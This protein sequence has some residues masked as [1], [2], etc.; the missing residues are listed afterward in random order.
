MEHLTLLNNK[1]IALV[2][3]SSKMETYIK[4]QTFSAQGK[5]Q[6]ESVWVFYFIIKSKL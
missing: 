2:D 1:N 3:L 5:N 6:A 4:T